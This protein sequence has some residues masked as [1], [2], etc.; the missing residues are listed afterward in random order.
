MASK[1][2]FAESLASSGF[3]NYDTQITQNLLKILKLTRCGSEHGSIKN[4]QDSILDENFI[5][6]ACVVGIH[7][8]VRKGIHAL[9]IMSISRSN[10]F[11][12][13]I[14]WN[15]TTS[16][17]SST[18]KRATTQRIGDYLRLGLSIRDKYKDLSTLKFAFSIDQ[19]DLV[20]S[21]QLSI[22]TKYANELEMPINIVFHNNADVKFIVDSLESAGV[23]NEQTQ[24][25]G[26]ESITDDLCCT[27]KRY[28][29]K[30]LHTPLTTRY[31]DG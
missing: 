15:K 3:I 2:V 14:D 22:T 25:S 19:N 30:V 28:N 27:L 23:L 29:C 6:D 5:F 4:I 20:K 8:L 21:E 12:N 7:E 9:D 26:I 18:N 31:P 11:N 24:L 10:D 16:G 1:R 17:F 13:K